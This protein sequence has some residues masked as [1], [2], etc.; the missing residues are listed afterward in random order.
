MP[1]V[2]ASA[3]PTGA[4]PGVQLEQKVG[5][6]AIGAMDDEAP[7]ETF[8]LGAD[9]GAMTFDTGRVI[10]S[11]RFRPSGRDGAGAFGLDKFDAAV[12][13]EGLFGRV[14]NLHHVAL[15]SG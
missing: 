9:F 14:D 15:R 12:I 4:E 7:T 6:G 1:A 11:P 10:R 3:F 2:H 8:G 13:G 5:R